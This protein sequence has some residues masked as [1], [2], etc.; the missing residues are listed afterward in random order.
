MINRG[1]KY[2]KVS[3]I[4]DNW[5]RTMKRFKDKDEATNFAKDKLEAYRN[6]DKRGNIVISSV[7]FR[8]GKPMNEIYEVFE[9]ERKCLWG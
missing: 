7:S 4:R 3:Y 6:K 2:Y 8:L 9:C 5:K 1:T